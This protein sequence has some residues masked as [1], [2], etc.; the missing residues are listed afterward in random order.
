[1]N[2]TVT[3]Y[4]TIE[5]DNEEEARRIADSLEINSKHDEQV[6]WN[7]LNTEVEQQPDF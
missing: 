2:F 4:L 7:S 5:A 1:M 6:F 3:L